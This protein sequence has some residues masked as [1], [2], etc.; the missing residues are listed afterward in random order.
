MFDAFPT[1]GLSQQEIAF[2][3]DIG[4]PE[5][6]IRHWRQ[7]R[8]PNCYARQLYRAWCGEQLPGSS[9]IWEGW[10][11]FDERLWSP[12]DYSFTPG[13]LRKFAYLR[14]VGALPC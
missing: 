6:T 1:D 14:Q 7:M 10:K 13:D 4:V 8:K 3:A 2:Y 12:E 9:E 5:R 11:F